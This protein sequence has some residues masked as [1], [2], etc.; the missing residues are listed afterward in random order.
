[1]ESTLATVDGG[2]GTNVMTAPGAA[3]ARIIR[4]HTMD[5]RSFGA[6]ATADHKLKLRRNLSLKAR[7]TS[8][9]LF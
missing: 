2:L 8:A 5:S 7:F 3:N 4:Q 9:T 6:D 1:M